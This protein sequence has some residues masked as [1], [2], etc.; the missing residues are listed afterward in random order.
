MKYVWN[1]TNMLLTFEHNELTILLLY[2][3]YVIVSKYSF[4]WISTVHEQTAHF[5]MSSAVTSQIKI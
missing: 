5:V 1:A 2:F 3:S 4:F